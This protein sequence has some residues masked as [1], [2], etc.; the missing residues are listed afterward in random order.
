[1]LVV[2]CGCVTAGSSLAW[3]GID[4]LS[5]C[6]FV[7]GSRL[8]GCLSFGLRSRLVAG[9]LVA[10]FS[11]DLAVARDRPVRNWSPV[12]WFA[13][14][15]QT[16]WGWLG[17]GFGWFAIGSHGWVRKCTVPYPHPPS[18]KPA[19]VQQF[20]LLLCERLRLVDSC[21]AMD[22]RGRSGSGWHQVPAP[23]QVCSRSGSPCRFARVCAP[24]CF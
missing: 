11:A 17:S 13:I 1:M 3:S 16:V 14:G 18:L 7:T 21:F 15:S 19:A 2:L 4:S 23:L 22:S 5:W 24:L 6:L 12:C 10:T 9:W 20:G 8:G